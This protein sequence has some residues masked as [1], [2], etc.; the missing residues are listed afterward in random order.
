MFESH[1]NEEMEAEVRRIE[2]RQR[3][4]A[5]GHPEWVNACAV[6]RCE[7]HSTA[8]TACEQCMPNR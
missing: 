6:C 4:S 1:Y 2:A 8:V 7:L 5:A 3:A